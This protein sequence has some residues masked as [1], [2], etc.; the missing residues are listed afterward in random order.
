VAEASQLAGDL[1]RP[2]ILFLREEGFYEECNEIAINRVLARRLAEEMKQKKI[3]EFV[4]S[5]V[6]DKSV[7]SILQSQ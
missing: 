4:D 7:K 5:P 2:I 6:R 1:V 3:T